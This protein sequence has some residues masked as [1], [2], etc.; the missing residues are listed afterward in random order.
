MP[1]GAPQPVAAR[2]PAPEPNRATATIGRAVTVNGDIMSQEDLFI[3]G[4]VQGNILLE[5]ARLTVGPNGKVRAD[6]K[7]RD[8]VIQGNV[9]GSVEATEKI[10]IRK[11]GTL[12]GDVKMAGIVI[13]DGAY[14]KGS[15]D[16]TRPAP[17]QQSGA[18]AA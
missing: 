17:K 15:I 14:F 11:E 12:V 5:Q 8:V 3:D 16:I 4:E 10:T 7:A 2:P 1:H 18:N 6:I 13:E 9:Q